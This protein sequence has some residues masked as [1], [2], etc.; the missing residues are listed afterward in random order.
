MQRNEYCFLLLLSRETSRSY[1]NIRLFLCFM[2]R[3]LLNAIR[4]W[5]LLLLSPNANHFMLNLMRQYL[6]VWVYWGIKLTSR[7]FYMLTFSTLHTTCMFTTLRQIEFLLLFFI[8]CF[9]AT[10]VP[11]ISQWNIYKPVCIDDG[12]VC[13]TFESVT[14]SDVEMNATFDVLQIKTCYLLFKWSR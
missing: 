3:V 9:Q 6:S 2:Q 11:N 14:V 1:L 4:M 12:G 10:A 5:M 7:S 13:N 8:N